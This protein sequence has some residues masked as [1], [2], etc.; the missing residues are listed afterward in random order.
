MDV[1]TLGAK[2]GRP[3]A[4]QVSRSGC[5]KFPGG[6]ALSLQQLGSLGLGSIPGLGTSGCCR[7]GPQKSAFDMNAH[8]TNTHTELYTTHTHT[9]TH[10]QSYSLSLHHTHTHT[11]THRAIAYPC[12]QAFPVWLQLTFL[13]Q[14]HT[15]F[16]HEMSV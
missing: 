11:H 15:S 12:I 14:F 1:Q 5:E 16:H 4:I 6:A 10:T 7:H 2:N 9:H 3:S 8:H 13:N